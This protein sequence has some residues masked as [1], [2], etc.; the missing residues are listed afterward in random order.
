MLGYEAAVNFQPSKE[1]RISSSGSRTQRV[2]CMN[3]STCSH[4][5]IKR[6]SLFGNKSKWLSYDS[7]NQLNDNLIEKGNC[8]EQTVIAPSFT[9]N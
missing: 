8:T 9:L 1:G 3:T 2:L 6:K 5:K 7:Q 4:I